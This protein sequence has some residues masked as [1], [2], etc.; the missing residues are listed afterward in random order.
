MKI[1]TTQL[2]A[3]NIAPQ[4]AKNLA[5]FNGNTKICDVD[6]SKIRPSNLGEKKYSFGLFADIHVTGN[7]ST[8]GTRFDKGVTFAESQG[9]SF[10]CVA[11]D[12]TTIGFWYP[13][14][15]G[16][17]NPTS[18]YYPDQFE[19]YRS[20]C[21]KHS[22]PIYASCGNHES[23][24]GYNITG[25]YTDIYGKDP[26]LVVNNLEKLQEYTGDGLLFT[27]TYGDDVFIFV[28]QSIGSHPMTDTSLQW[29]YET[30]EANRNKRCFVFVHSYV[31]HNSSGNPLSLHALPLFDFWGETRK[32]AF[33]NLMKHYK[34]TMLFHGHSHVRPEVQFDVKHVN[35]SEVLGF[36][37][38]SIPSSANSRAI[39]ETD[40]VK[41]LKNDN[42]SFCYIADAY[43]NHVVM[44]AYNILEDKY[45]EIGQY[46][47]DMKIQTI[48]A[49]TF[50][51]S[52]GTIKTN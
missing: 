35:Y 14:V 23:Y 29:L 32:T 26:T 38:F 46:C 11:G 31:S 15:E 9:A 44:K 8:A 33:I 24:N 5:I 51:D 3:E 34:N 49:N 36:R 10:C 52:T 43:E 2:I 6:I 25:T 16:G 13:I 17:S 22:I 20:I 21:K 40:G 30:L 28:G 37:D 47:I 39:V 12:I 45:V 18:Y 19:E 1:G 50:T 48:E 27:K 4:N 7:N 41:A 42:S